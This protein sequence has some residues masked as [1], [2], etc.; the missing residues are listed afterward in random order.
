MIDFNK[1]NNLK[2]Y[3]INLEIPMRDID[4]KN[5]ADDIICTTM[6]LSTQKLSE[7]KFYKTLTE[8]DCPPKAFCDVNDLC[9]IEKH[10]RSYDPEQCIRCWKQILEVL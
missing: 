3:Y 7:E 8:I 5:A 9:L 2:E 6:L 10:D 4:S 1:V